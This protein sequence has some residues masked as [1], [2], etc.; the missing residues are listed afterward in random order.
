MR[1]IDRTPVDVVVILGSESD[2]RFIKQP[3]TG[4]DEIFDVFSIF[5]ACGV[6]YELSYISSHRNAEALALHCM[7]L[8]A[9][10]GIGAASGSA[11]LPGSMAGMTRAQ[12]PILGVPLPRPEFPDADDAMKS[13]VHMPPGTPVAVCGIGNWGMINAVVH[14]CQIVALGNQEVADK[15]AAYRRDKNK[16]PQIGVERG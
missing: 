5:G 15:L 7:N 9:A 10:V 6:T 12:I 13:M 16:T 11:G 2:L 8:G 14:A 3:K 1:S 4:S